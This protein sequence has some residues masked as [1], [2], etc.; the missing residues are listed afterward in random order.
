MSSLRG[1]TR[2]HSA[3]GATP[4]HLFQSTTADKENVNL[5]PHSNVSSCA[6]REQLRKGNN[7]CHSP[8]SALSAGGTTWHVCTREGKEKNLTQCA[9]KRLGT[10]GRRSLMI[11]LPTRVS[12]TSGEGAF[13]SWLHK[14]TKITTQM[15]EIT[16]QGTK[17]TTRMNRI[18]YT[19]ARNSLHT[20]GWRSL[21]MNFPKRVSSASGGGAFE[22]SLHRSTKFT[23]KIHDINPT[24]T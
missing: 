18:S 16:T 13:G 1:S 9:W 3:R 17:F 21:M 14:C 20:W 19:N 5:F 10:R 23:T 24:N 12:S 4:H 11:N 8:P 7:L 2:Q 15:I 6:Q 22:S